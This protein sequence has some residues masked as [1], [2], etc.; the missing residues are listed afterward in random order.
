MFYNRPN[1]M[2]CKTIGLSLT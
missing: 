2:A 1:I